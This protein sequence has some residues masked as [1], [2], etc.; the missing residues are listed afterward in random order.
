MSSW[1]EQTSLETVPGHIIEPSHSEQVPPV[2]RKLL[3]QE[4]E[5]LPA[6][7]CL[8]GQGDIGIYLARAEQIPETLW[9][10][11]R[12]REETFRLIGEGTGNLVDLDTYDRT[13]EHIFAWSQTT[14]QVLG[15]YRI[16]P[17]DK[18]MSEGGVGSIYTHSLFEFDEAFID[19]L[20]PAL[21]MGRS[22]VRPE[23]QGSAV[24]NLLWRGI[25][26]YLARNP[27]YRRLV[28]VVS[29]DRNYDDLVISLMTHYLTSNHGEKDL[30][31][32]LQPRTPWERPT[33]SELRELGPILETIN[34][35]MDLC[36][37]VSRLQ[38]DGRSIPIL[39][40]HYML[41][42]AK[43]LG[44]NVDPDFSD[45]VDGFISLDL[46]D[47]HPRKLAFFMGTRGAPK[48]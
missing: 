4:V 24:L 31:T 3:L 19:R 20:N 10:I 48:S 29:I 18:L 44:F 47:V 11:G 30:A 34:S 43:V 13:Y 46:A 22:F 8:L 23:H 15:A 2:P 42:G 35:P 45:V 1:I 37:A 17:L 16:G 40:K 38:P 28:G 9:E 39:L 27:R 6:D 36:R 41:L 26:S 21:E 12:L 5:S 7:Q 32:L 14:E 25:G 33:S